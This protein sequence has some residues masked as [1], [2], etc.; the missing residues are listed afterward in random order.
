MGNDPVED[1][2]FLR[3]R[4]DEISAA[5]AVAEERRVRAENLLNRI[6]AQLGGWREMVVELE[7]WCSD[8]ARSKGML[9]AAD[10]IDEVAEAIRKLMKEHGMGDG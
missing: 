1:L 2:D 10:Q 7:D 3:R 6:A 9:A 8:E 4:T 5:Y